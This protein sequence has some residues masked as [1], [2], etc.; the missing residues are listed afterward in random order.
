MKNITYQEYWNEIEPIVKNCFD[1]KEYD[2]IDEDTWTERLQE[3]IDGHQWIIY[4]GRNYE[5]LLLSKNET[6]IDDIG[7]EAGDFAKV[8]TQAAYFAMEADC[9]DYFSNNRDEIVKEAA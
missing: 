4:T 7:F 5:V 6:A 3:Q 1:S 2:D 9:L 8:V